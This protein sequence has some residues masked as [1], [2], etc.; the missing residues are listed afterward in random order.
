VLSNAARKHNHKHPEFII[1]KFSS[2]LKSPASDVFTGRITIRALRATRSLDRLFD[3][4]YLRDSFPADLYGGGP[5]F[6]CLFVGI[7]YT[8]H[9]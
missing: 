4:L 5:I 8:M 9:A 7:D 2:R 6:M 3:R 1:G